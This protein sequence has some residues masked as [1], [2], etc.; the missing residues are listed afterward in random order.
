M[1]I[2]QNI[3]GEIF[4][5]FTGVYKEAG[6]EIYRKSICIVLYKRMILINLWRVE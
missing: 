1:K 2:E 3:T 4:T 6:K 5:F